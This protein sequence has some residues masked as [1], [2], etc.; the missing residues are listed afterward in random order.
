MRRGIAVYEAARALMGAITPFYDE[1]AK[2]TSR[3]LS[4][5]SKLLGAAGAPGRELGLYCGGLR[6]AIWLLRGALCGGS[7][8]VQCV[9]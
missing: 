3:P 1:V 4:A 8:S 6:T 9:Y 5:S 2:V 7:E